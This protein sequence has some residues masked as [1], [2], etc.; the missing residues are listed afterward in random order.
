MFSR[1]PQP[2]SVLCFNVRGTL[3]TIRPEL[4]I[5]KLGYFRE[6][7]SR[8]DAQEYK[9]NTRVPLEIFRVFLT[10]IEDD[11]YPITE[12]NWGFMTRLSDE[13]GFRALS[14]ACLEFSQSLSS[15]NTTNLAPLL[16]RLHSLEEGHL[17]LE[18]A[19][20]DE[21]Q[22][23]NAP[24]KR[25]PVLKAKSQLLWTEYVSRVN[26]LIDAVVNIYLEQMA[27]VMVV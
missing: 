13:F 17:A 10:M 27:S 3:F 7:P 15:P 5:E 18:L 23:V 6:D 21:R 19:L 26:R 2:P 22:R 4:A 25:N 12:S 9:V 16:S 8:A 14:N 1:A 11:R 20:N 24:L